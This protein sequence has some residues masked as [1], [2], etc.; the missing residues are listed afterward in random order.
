MIT[1]MGGGATVTEEAEAAEVTAG[2]NTIRGEGE[3]EAVIAGA[4]VGGESLAS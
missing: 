4:V 3:G 2:G 1:T